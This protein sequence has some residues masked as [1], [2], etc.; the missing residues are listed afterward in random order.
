MILHNYLLT[1]TPERVAI[2]DL[3]GHFNELFGLMR[4]C[5]PSTPS[6]VLFRA[7]WVQDCQDLPRMSQTAGT[8]AVGGRAHAPRQRGKR[9][10][11]YGETRKAVRERLTAPRRS[12]DQGE[13]PVAGRQTVAQF[14]DR[15]QGDAVTVTVRPRTYRSYAQFVRLYLAPALGHHQLAQLAP[16]HVQALLNTPLASGG[17]DGAGV[18]AR[19]AQYA[20]A[21]L[22]KALARAHKGGPVHRNAG[23]LVD[24]PRSARPEMR[25]LGRT[26]RAG[27][28][29]RRAGIASR[30][31]TRWRWRS[32]SGR[33]RS[34]DFDGTTS[35]G[36]R[37]RSGCGSS[38]S[39]STAGPGWSILKARRGGRGAAAGPGGPP[40]RRAPRGGGA[41]AGVGARLPVDHRHAARAEQPHQAL[42]GAP[43]AGRAVANPLP[44]PAPFVRV[45]PDRAGHP[46]A[47][48]AGDARPQPDRPDDGHLRPH[49]PRG[50][51]PGGDG[52]GSAVRHGLT[53]SCGTTAIAPPARRLPSTLRSNKGLGL[54]RLGGQRK[55]LS[56]KRRYPDAP[57]APTLPRRVQG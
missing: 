22:R 6:G 8:R 37:G 12:L 1:T 27:S 5:W 41:L 55:M 13:T 15:W 28:S 53:A 50:A 29:R 11:F 31:C 52:D 20:R 40:G 49:L 36:R 17:E 51:A 19:A 47:D 24:S 14:L 45:A 35:T 43:R 25:A 26:R 30:R 21:V 42:R 9:K 46:G 54:T 32:G 33:G 2:G 3:H 18:S 57:H 23:T 16:Q 7:V 10:R 56:P 39:A 34:W 44:R 38:C 4:L 48:R